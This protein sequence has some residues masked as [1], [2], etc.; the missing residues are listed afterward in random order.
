LRT[1]GDRHAERVGLGEA[2]GLW[3][4]EALTGVPGPYAETQRRRLAE[5]RLTTV[6]RHATLTLG[7]AGYDEVIV[8][9]EP[10]I[11]GHPMRESLH[12]L[13]MTALV[14][15]GRV[16]EALDVYR[17]V[18]RT[19]VEQTGT[20]PSVTLRRLHEQILAGEL[21]PDVRGRTVE[22]PA[23]TV[24]VPAEVARPFVG[25]PE[26]LSRLRDAVTAVAQGH[27][28]SVWIEGEPGIG[29]SALLAEGLRDAEKQGCRVGRGVG[30]ELAQRLPLTVLMECLDLD[31][32]PAAGD[33]LAAAA[34]EPGA[35]PTGA[36][37]DQVQM[38]VLEACGR[39]PLVLVVD[40]VQWADEASLLAWHTLYRLTTRV[41]LLLVT[42][43]RTAPR[44]RR[45]GLLRAELTADGTDVVSLGAF[46]PQE[47]DTFVCGAGADPALA[48]PAGALSAGNPLYLSAI[49]TA[50]AHGPASWLVEDPAAVLPAA[51][52]ATVYSHLDLLSESTR[53]V[54]RA[55]AFLGESATVGE[56]SAV[57]E[58]SVT[59]LIGAVQEALSAG[60]LTEAGGERLA[61]R[62]PLVRRVLHRSTPTALRLMLHRQF[63]EKLAA[64]GAVTRVAEQIVAAGEPAD[65]WV[66][67][68]VAA[69]LDVLRSRAPDEVVRALLARSPGPP[70]LQRRPPP[71]GRRLAARASA[72]SG[73]AFRHRTAL[74][75]DGN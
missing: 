28:G 54:V 14:R 75:S 34:A 41:P 52:T 42:A 56:L 2:L 61:F 3:H 40:D 50:A 47:T 1:A 67:A 8:T 74:S 10:L 39:S 27:G 21:G 22:S 16:P 73:S 57:T 35:D 13:L 69:H 19:L 63:A 25:R 71:P 60:V 43:G 29:K 68:W 6:E 66:T 33:A 5:L 30:D 24:A 9:L 53:D 7:A 11:D 58:R 26:Q 23:V 48:G 49:L 32:G 17:R 36:V 4:G 18:H 44:G 65:P 51:L 72:A 12:A 45:L 59:A 62:H 20:E 38:M 37:L 70:P 64:T 15:R 31:G 46:T 55:A